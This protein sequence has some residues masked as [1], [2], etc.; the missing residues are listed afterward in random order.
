MAGE[1]PRTYNPA[2][3]NG[4][5]KC[6]ECGALLREHEEFWIGIA[7][8]AVVGVAGL[9]TSI[10]VAEIVHVHL[11]EVAHGRPGL[12]IDLMW[13]LGGLFGFLGAIIHWA[14]KGKKK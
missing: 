6:T 11:M 1:K 8:A 2:P 10:S 9:V 12:G 7:K 3:L 4:E 13:V 14:F 5:E